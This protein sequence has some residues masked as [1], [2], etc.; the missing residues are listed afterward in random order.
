MLVLGFA[1]AVTGFAGL[2]GAGFS[3]EQGW[4]VVLGMLGMAASLVGGIIKAASAS[5]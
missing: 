1:V 2:L 3:L 4:L 5:E